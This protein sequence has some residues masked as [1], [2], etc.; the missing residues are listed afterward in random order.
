MKKTQA[1]VNYFFVDESG[2]P[3]FYD[4]KG[5]YIVGQSGCSPILLLGFMETQDPVPIRSALREL[6][7]EIIS[8]PYFQGVPSLA[9][10]RLAFHAKDD[11][12]EI[13]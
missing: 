10:T 1:G 6:Q 9:G 11:L 12:P 5:N 7:H 3:T 13:R 8:D 4:R 2:D